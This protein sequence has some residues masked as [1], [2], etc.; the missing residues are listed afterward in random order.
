MIIINLHS[1]YVINNYYLPSYTSNVFLYFFDAAKFI[2][3][4]VPINIYNLVNI[5]VNF[6]SAL[7]IY[8]KVFFLVNI[9]VA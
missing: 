5:K 6:Y 8:K 7:Y 3:T 9:Y 2:N 1:L 4:S